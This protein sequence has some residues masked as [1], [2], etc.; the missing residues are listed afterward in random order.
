LKPTE[1][2]KI[3]YLNEHVCYEAEELMFCH[4]FLVSVFMHKTELEQRG[5]LEALRNTSLEHFGLHARN[6]LEFLFYGS[7]E[8]YARATDYIAGWA[9]IRI[10]TQNIRVL[11]RRVNAEI[12]HLGWERLNVK[13][14]EKG[15][16]P[17]LIAQ[18]LLDTYELFLSKLDDH[19]KQERVKRLQFN[20]S[21]YK[22]DIWDVFGILL[23]PTG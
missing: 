10:K 18:D 14:E 23:G 4:A 17:L 19:Y 21:H 7:L 16:E 3:E 11:E 9:N 2:Q 12:A 13:P 22:T 20:L 8:G 15:W 6:L 1:A 5:L